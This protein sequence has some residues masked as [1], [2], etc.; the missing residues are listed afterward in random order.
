MKICEICDR[1]K[2]NIRFRF[3]RYNCELSDT[4][5]KCERESYMDNDELQG[6]EDIAE[7][8]NKDYF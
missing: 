1:K 3:D 8:F 6:W 4:C 2:K 5:K 7:K